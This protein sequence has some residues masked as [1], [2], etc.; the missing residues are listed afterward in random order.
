MKQVMLIFFSFLIFF[1]NIGISVF[2][3][4]CH[5]EGVSKS[6]FFALNNCNEDVNTESCC[7]EEEI[8][9]QSCCE[10]EEKDACCSDETLVIQVNEKYTQ[11]HA[12]SKILTTE[13]EVPIFYRSSKYPVLEKILFCKKNWKDPPPKSRKSILIQHQV[14]RI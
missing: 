2:T 7:E 6:Y 10:E 9:A 3:H 12:L 5:E 11:N 13:Y 8:D 1:G 4:I 14:F